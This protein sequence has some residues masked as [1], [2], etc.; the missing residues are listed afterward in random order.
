MLQQSIEQF[1]LIG[2][3]LFAIF[4]LAFGLGNLCYGIVLSGSQDK[5]RLIGYG[6][7]YWAFTSFLGLSNEYL[8]MNWVDSLMEYNGKVFQPIFRL[9]LGI[10]LLRRSQKIS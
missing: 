9:I 6:F 7:L 1:S 5:T 4:A 2:N 3:S 10:W 8:S